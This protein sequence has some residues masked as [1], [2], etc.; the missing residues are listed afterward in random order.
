[1]KLLL[2]LSIFV[3]FRGVRVNAICPGFGNETNLKYYPRPSRDANEL[4]AKGQSLQQNDLADDCVKAISFLT[5][6]S[7]SFITGVIIRVDGG[8]SINSFI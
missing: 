5:K 3:Q 6:E 4:I 8:M 1:M 7:A 2:I